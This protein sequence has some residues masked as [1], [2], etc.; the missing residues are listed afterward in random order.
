MIIRFPI[1]K[2]KRSSSDDE[3]LIYE[4][5]FL[6]DE[7]EQV[8]IENDYVNVI[9]N[10]DNDKKI[11]S[12][13]QH[14]L[15][16]WSKTRSLE[17]NI[18][19]D[20]RTFVKQNKQ[21]FLTEFSREGLYLKGDIV[22]LEEA[23]VKI[24]RKKA[25]EYGAVLRK[26]PSLI[27]KELLERS[28]YIYNFPQNIYRVSELNHSVAD[29][30][31]FREA[32][33]EEISTDHLFTNTEKFLQPCVCYHAYDEISKDLPQ[34][35]GIDPFIISSTGK[36]YRHEHKREI[37][38]TRNIDFLMHEIIYFGYEQQ[39]SDFRNKLIEMTWDTF[40]EL[41]FNGYIVT[42]TDPF[43]TYEDTGRSFYQI[44]GALKYELI[45]SP[46]EDIKVAL[47]SFNNCKDVLCNIFN[48]R[49]NNEPLFSGCTAYGIDRWI[50]AFIYTHG[51]C[52]KKWPK[53]IQELL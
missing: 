30:N 19:K 6:C 46:N 12:N 32:L 51:T 14:L 35:N 31:S 4:A 28:R 34:M 16:S 3:R 10:G 43:F 2:K 21:N 52:S 17:P 47:T 37:S 7:V 53:V 18:I 5:Y 44:A 39:I 20:N 29:I 38:P 25:I 48:I 8:Y 23:F 40:L 26:Y 36:C 9:Y 15:E 22:L 13:V 1:T 41:G 42:A 50:Q 33:E 24:F 11:I 27:N 49:Q 45:F